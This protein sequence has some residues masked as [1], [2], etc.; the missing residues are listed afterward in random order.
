M[1]LHVSKPVRM[2]L[3]CQLSGFNAPST[4]CVVNYE[5]SWI[6][7]IN[8]AALPPSVGLLFCLLMSTAAA[9]TEDSDI[10]L[11]RPHLSRH[12]D[13]GAAGMPFYIPLLNLLLSVAAPGCF[14]PKWVQ[15]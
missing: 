7:S 5:R 4:V 1:S 11:D 3:P 13:N 6:I 2:L 12:L 15:N 8:N 14:M 9:T 10:V